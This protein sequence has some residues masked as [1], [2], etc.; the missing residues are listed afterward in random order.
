LN[1]PKDRRSILKVAG[2]GL[3]AGAA[4]FDTARAEDK[5]DDKGESLPNIPAGQTH[6]L[7]STK[8]T[9]SMGVLDPAR[10]PALTID[11]GDIVHYPNTWTVWGNEAK[12][13]LSFDEREPIRKRYPSGP[14]SNVGPVAVRGAEPG[15]ILEMRWL[16]LYPIDWGWNSFPLGVGALPSD[17]D[18]PYVHY[19]RFDAERR[20]AAFVNGVTIPL[21]PFQD[22]AALQPKDDKPVSGILAGPYGGNLALPEMVVGTS[23]LLPVQRSGGLFW[24]SA[25]VAAQG[26]GVV[27]QTGIETAME[28]MRIQFVLHKNVPLD[29]PTVETPTH[30]IGFGFAD[31]SLDAALVACLRGIIK[32]TSRNAKI[33]PRD[34]YPLCSMAASFRVTQYSNQTGSVYTSVPPRAVHCML[35]KTVFSADLRRAISQA[36]RST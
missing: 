27:D 10:P 12:Y 5:V 9:V 18:K 25:S 32:W 24:T 26:D 7:E 22:I 29:G 36:A 11:S 21:A 4:A 8:A 35:P 14:Y 28:D 3:V 31:D 23:L 17:F 6:I 19:F 30:W 13:G 16:K 20:N 1:I 33:D 34:V 15:D 2:A